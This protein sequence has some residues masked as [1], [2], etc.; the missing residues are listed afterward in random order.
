MVKNPPAN[1]GD[2][3]DAG[4][5]PG[6]GRPLEGGMAPI[7]VFLPGESHGLRSLAGHKES[8]TIK[9]L[10]RYTYSGLNLT[11]HLVLKPLPSFPQPL[12]VSFCVQYLGRDNSN[13][14]RNE[15]K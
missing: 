7:P 11:T 8:Y 3:G 5:I 12:F 1:A 2:T 10:N 15:V 9:Q 4:L 6:L 14:E 13:I